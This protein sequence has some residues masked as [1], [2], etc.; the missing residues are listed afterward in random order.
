MVAGLFLSFQFRNT[1]SLFHVPE[2]YPALG[3]TG[4]CGSLPG[5]PPVSRALALRQP[6]RSAAHPFCRIDVRVRGT[7][8]FVHVASPLRGSALGVAARSHPASVH[9]GKQPDLLSILEGTP[10]LR[11]EET[12]GDACT[13][14]RRG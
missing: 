2:T 5:I 4:T 11:A 9:Y 6:A 14:A 13:G 7:A 1:T 12:G 8:G 3:D 10:A